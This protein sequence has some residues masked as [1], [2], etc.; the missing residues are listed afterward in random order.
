LVAGESARR[1]VA[2]R[3]GAR[4]VSVA[5]RS[6]PRDGSAASHGPSTRLTPPGPRLTLM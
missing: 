4:R 1:A 2:V 5:A 6:G 3:R